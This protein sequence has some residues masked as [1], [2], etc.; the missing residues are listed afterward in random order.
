MLRTAPRLLPTV[1]PQGALH[2][3]VN[4]D[5]LMLPSTSRTIGE[6]TPD[7]LTVELRQCH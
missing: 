6:P 5:K 3:Q 4:S 1:P 2:R 7:I